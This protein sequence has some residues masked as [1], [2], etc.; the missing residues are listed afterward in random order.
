MAF[1]C[2]ESVDLG[3]VI[4][5]TDKVITSTDT[6][7]IAEVPTSVIIMYVVNHYVLF[8]HV[9][10]VCIMYPL[11]MSGVIKSSLNFLYI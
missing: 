6:Q 3:R 9:S 1:R 5:G 8:P 2:G 11:Y 7:K 10:T 4:S